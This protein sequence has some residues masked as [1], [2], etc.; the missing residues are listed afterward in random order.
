MNVKKLDKTVYNYIFEIDDIKRAVYRNIIC[1][2]NLSRQYFIS[3][4]DIR[5]IKKYNSDFKK[6][7]YKIIKRSNINTLDDYLNNLNAI[8]IINSN[9]QDILKQ[10]KYKSYATIKELENEYN[11]IN[12]LIGAA[13]SFEVFINSHTTFLILITIV[14]TIVLLT[15]VSLFSKEYLLTIIGFFAF[16]VFFIA[17]LLSIKTITN[18]FE[19][20]K[21]NRTRSNHAILKS[22]KTRKLKNNFMSILHK[23]R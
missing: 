14:F 2:K 21:I 3:K 17:C 4:S 19:I 20:D 22:R 8:I 18:R 6:L 1:N 12:Y 10:E 23:I 9:I 11:K 16:I 15:L 7:C 5:K 13:S